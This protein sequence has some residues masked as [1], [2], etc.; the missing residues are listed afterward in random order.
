MLDAYSVLHQNIQDKFNE[1][2]VEINSPHYTSLRD[3]NL[4]TIPQSYLPDEYKSPV[5]ENHEVN[6]SETVR[7]KL[8]H[9]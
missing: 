3:G 5:F 8:K 2:G 9:T 7:R 6:G 1:A 4:T